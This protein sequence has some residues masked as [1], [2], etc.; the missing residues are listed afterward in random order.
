MRKLNIFRITE[1]TQDIWLLIIPQSKTPH[2]GNQQKSRQFRYSPIHHWLICSHIQSS[3]GKTN[4]E[5]TPVPLQSPYGNSLWVLC[6]LRRALVS[7]TFS[8]Y[9]NKILM[10]IWDLIFILY[11]H[12]FLTRKIQNWRGKITQTFSL[13]L[14]QK[15]HTCN[16]LCWI[17]ANGLNIIAAPY[18]RQSSDGLA[19]RTWHTLI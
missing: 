11:I 8:W 14:Q 13:Q 6:R 12:H 19:E 17:L 1:S 3:Q 4:K 7:P 2:H 16:A 9:I 10:V 18:G 5:A 15:N